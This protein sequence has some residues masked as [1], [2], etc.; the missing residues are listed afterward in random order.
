MSAWGIPLQINTRDGIFFQHVFGDA[1][2]KSPASAFFPLARTL[3]YDSFGTIGRKSTAADNIDGTGVIGFEAGAWTDTR[4]TGGDEF[5]FFIE[6]FPA[7]A[8][9]GGG[10]SPPDKVLIA[11]FTV[12]NPGPTAGVFGSM[13]INFRHTIP[14]KKN[15]GEFIV[16]LD[17]RL[18]SFDNQI[19]APGALALLGTAGLLGCRR[20]R[21]RS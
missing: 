18:A 12:V 19:P 10:D 21:R 2:N 16:V 17:T 15:P 13:F 9:A 20:R 4:F 3:Q 14:D 5:S 8:S 1:A 6:G 7:Q 11:Q